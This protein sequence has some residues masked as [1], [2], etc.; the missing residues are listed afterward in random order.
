MINDIYSINDIFSNVDSILRNLDQ[1]CAN[2]SLTTSNNTMYTCPKVSRVT[3]NGDITVVHFADNTKTMVKR[4][5]ADNTDRQTAVVYAILKRMFAKGIKENGE[6]DSV[7]FCNW[8]NKL[9]KSGYDQQLAEA[10]EKERKA[11]AK[12]AHAAKQKAEHEAAMKRRAARRAEE[13][14]VEELA[15]KMLASKAEAPKMINETTKKTC[16]KQTSKKSDCDCDCNKSDEYVRPN[17]K[18]KDFTADERKAYWRYHN[19]LRK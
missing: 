4:S 10:T 19:S 6:V 15:K 11:K 14:E 7:G 5:D 12:A 16:C 1:I 8:L 13:L 3:F 18:F 2:Y 9:V 17:K